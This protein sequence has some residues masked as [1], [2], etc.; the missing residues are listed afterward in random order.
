[1]T[2]SLRNRVLGTAL[3]AALL[4][5][6]VGLAQRAEAFLG[7]PFGVGRVEFDAPPANGPEAPLSV[8]VTDKQGR[9]YYPATIGGGDAGRAVRNLVERIQR[10]RLRA[11]G[12]LAAGVPV[13]RP[14]VYFLFVGQEPLQLTLIGAQTVP[15]AVTPVADPVGQQRLMERW[16]RAY[17][18]AHRGLFARKPNYPPMAEVYLQSMLARRMGLPLPEQR[19]RKSWEDVF[20][21]ELGLSVNSEATR[22][23][24][25]QQRMLGQADL[26]QEATLPVPSAVADPGLSLAE[27]LAGVKIEPIATRVPEECLY[28]HFGNYPNYLWYSD[29]MRRWGGDLRNMM[30][31]R[32]VRYELNKRSEQQMILRQTEL[33]RLFGPTVIA[34]AAIIGSDLYQPDGAAIGMLFQARNSLILGTSLS[35]Q[36]SEALKANRQAREEKLQIAG[37]PVSF[38]H[39]PDNAVRS[40]YA[41]DGDFHFVT[42]SRTL[43]RRFLE[44]GA[45]RTS[46]GG[47]KEFRLARAA[48]P[49]DGKDTIFAY[50]SSA[51]FR[52]MVRPEYRVEISRRL[53]AAADIDAVQLAQ[54]AAASERQPD[55]SIDALRAGGYLPP[56]FGQRPDGSRTLIDTNAVY[57][58]LRGARGTFV[59]VPDVEVKAIT[60]AEAD[61]YARFAEYYATQF[62]GPIEPIV[63]A[64]RREAAEGGRRERVVVDAKMEPLNRRRYDM[65]AQRVGPPDTLRLAPL[66]G[67]VLFVE[68][69]LQRQRLFVGL[70]DFGAPPQTREGGLDGLLNML[71][72]GRLRDLFYGYLGTVGETGPLGILDR[73]I[74]TPADA[75]G[76]A[77]SAGLMWRR[78]VQPFHVFSLHREILDQVT[79]QL[80]LEQAE[81]PAQVRVRVADLSQAGLAPMA[82]KWAY[83]RALTGTEGNL[84]LIQ[85]MIEQFHVPPHDA[86]PAA[87][88]LL[89]ASLVC[90]LGGRY[91]YRESPDGSGRW[92]STALDQ[93]AP[94]ASGGRISF[95]PLNW[96]RGLNA[97]AVFAENRLSLHAEVDMELSAGAIPTEP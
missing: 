2:V 85:S 55:N 13:A 16:W 47:T 66:P 80:R 45:G 43:V 34:D 8:L 17:S 29:L 10:P 46:L 37:K 5:P 88:L 67:D 33:S 71:P 95:P 94:E 38:I 93:P 72:T 39:T 58:S 89:G 21:H 11:L 76:F 48:H 78:D 87:E 30:S 14:A 49:A 70:R 73:S 44:T 42:T 40:F 31:E 15:L 22:L 56:E 91:V 4:C 19:G 65:I 24:M 52:N 54:F 92:T 9:V 36:R 86:L 26:G 83:R 64:L 1:M 69:I 51:F 79:P 61:E 90:P 84:R 50:L 18:D 35:S 53:Q 27:P 59:P 41:A 82:Q 6:S 96:F 57:D 28:I 12:E 68:A 63:V 23:S 20:A 75:G 7:Q 32:G 25:L 74:I 60:P 3:L 97:D 62:G 77:R 81:R